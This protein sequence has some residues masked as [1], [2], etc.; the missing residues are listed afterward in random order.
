MKVLTRT[1][2]L[3]SICTL[4]FVGCDTLNLQ[5]P[6]EITSE[7][8]WQDEGLMKSFLA[9]VYPE[10]GHGLASP[11]KASATSDAVHTHGWAI[12]PYVN[13]SVTPS[14]MGAFGDGARPGGLGR[15]GPWL[16]FRW[17]QSYNQIRDLNIFLQEAAKSEAVSQSV[18]E[19]LLGEAYFMRAFFYAG[20][21]RAYGGVPLIA[22]VF[23][24]QSEQEALQVPRGSFQETVN[25]ITAD[26]DSAATRLPGP[27]NARRPGA[28]HKGAAAA[29]RC[30][31][32]LHAASDLF[33]E[34]PSGMPETGYTGGSQQ[35]RW[36]QAKE[37]CGSL[38]DKGWYSLKQ[39]DGPAGY[40][41]IL[42]YEGNNESGT[43][44]ARHFT[45]QGDV[46][47]RYPR[48][49]NPNGYVG[50]TGDAPTQQHVDAYEMADGSEFEWEGAD[51]EATNEP[52]DAKNPYDNRD[53]RFYANILYN[54]AEW[55]QRPKGARSMDPRGVAQTGRYETQGGMRWGLDTRN[56]PRQPWNGTWTGYNLKKFLDDR[57]PA[58]EKAFDT[59][60]PIFRYAEVLL[61]Y[62]EASAE[63]G[64][65]QDALRTVNKVRN[66]VGMPDVPADGGPNRTLIERIRQERRVE[67]A[68][69]G[70]RFF[71]VRRW[72]IAPE[73]LSENVH[74][75]EVVGRLTD[76]N[77]PEA[78]LLV[79]NY[80]DYEY[81][82]RDVR[83]RFW[84]D[85]M[86]FLPIP[87][88][89]IRRNPSLNQNP[90]Y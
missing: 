89:E 66:R 39:V 9:N 12:P 50:W 45:E 36:Q 74:Q 11:K 72:M 88:D 75:V 13:A 58:T 16:R 44:L 51:P 83:E 21:M 70:F 43:I 34:N 57:I 29:L 17:E 55:L 87:A 22:G 33:A 42:A 2:V 15:A 8:I 14:N 79:D 31:V 24:L 65:T 4:L 64:N 26:L 3:V 76:Q 20:L 41:H 7:A 53:P 23:E 6:D 56:G 1:L 59:S 25:F 19:A 18:K 35:D 32:R 38:I 60:Y 37:A 28:A 90:G 85:K 48:L 62:A 82:V 81:N 40:H 73:T 47:P 61:N 30:R 52:V 67:L 69:E 54:G 77:D 84:E 46:D 86:Y 71:D 63:L 5:P 49:V 10:L 68:F 27:N 78:E 80:Y